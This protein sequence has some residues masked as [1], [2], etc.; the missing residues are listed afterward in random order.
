MAL[1]MMASVFFVDFRSK[2]NNVRKRMAH[3][4]RKLIII[5]ITIVITKP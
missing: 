5:E 1:A 2:Y 3:A 4:P